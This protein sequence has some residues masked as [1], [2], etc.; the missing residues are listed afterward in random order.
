LEKIGITNNTGHIIR[1]N[2]TVITGFD[3]ADNQYNTLSKEEI[4]SYLNQQRPCPSTQQLVNQLNLVKLISKNTELLPNRTTTGYV[5]YKPLDVKIPG[6]WKLS[7]YEIPVETNSAG[8]PTK[9]VNFEF[10]SLCKKYEDTYR[11][12]SPFAKP[13]VISTK[14]IK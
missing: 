4:A 13:V 2:S 11:Q 12:D 14:E 9:T 10:K 1:L 3:P 8:I 6:V 5:L 7:F